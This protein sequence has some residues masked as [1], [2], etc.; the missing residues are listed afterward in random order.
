MKKLNYF[1]TIEYIVVR[2]SFSQIHEK[3]DEMHNLHPPDKDAI[4]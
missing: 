4:Q 3:I 1:Y 2:R